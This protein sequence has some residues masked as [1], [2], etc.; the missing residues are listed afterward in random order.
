MINNK[1]P[2]HHWGTDNPDEKISLEISPNII[3]FLWCVNKGHFKQHNP[4]D[5][6]HNKMGLG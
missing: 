3:N 4:L 1:S 2:Y 5:P 6:L